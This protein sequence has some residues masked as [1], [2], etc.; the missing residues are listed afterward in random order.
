MRDETRRMNTADWFLIL[1]V[2]F[3]VVGVLFRFFGLRGREREELSAISVTARWED[4]DARTVACLAS[5]EMLFTPAGEVFG[6]VISVEYVPAEVEILSGGMLYRVASPT[7]VNA[8][9][10]IEIM[11][12]ISRESFFNRQG[13]RMSAG[14]VLRLY[15]RRTELSLELLSMGLSPLS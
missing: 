8:T 12:R 13:E 11:G 3:S 6:R 7:R 5:G 2:F 15:S 14:Q 9:L 1:L 10:E 4:T